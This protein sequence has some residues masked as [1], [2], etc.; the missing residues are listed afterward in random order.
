M[1]HQIILFVAT[2]LCGG[3]IVTVYILWLA[4]LFSDRAKPQSVYDEIV[5][6][7]IVL[8]RVES[9]LEEEIYD[10]A[11]VKEAKDNNDEYVTSDSTDDIIYGR[12]ECAESLKNMINKWRSEL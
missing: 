4:G 8:K 6:D 5:R 10:G 7:A 1:N 12:H 9:W 11:Q 2:F 3:A